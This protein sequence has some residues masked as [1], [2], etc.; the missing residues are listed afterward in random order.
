MLQDSDFYKRSD[1]RNMPDFRS[2]LRE[3]IKHTRDEL[4]TGLMREVKKRCS[5]S[6]YLRI[7]HIVAAIVVVPVNG[8]SLVILQYRLFF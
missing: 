1:S 2:A 4:P 7:L 5:F 8:N 3:K 6:L